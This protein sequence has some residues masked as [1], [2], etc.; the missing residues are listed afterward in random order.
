MTSWLD[1]VMGQHIPIVH[2]LIHCGLILERF[3]GKKRKK[4]F[5]RKYDVSTSWR[6]DVIDFFSSLNIRIHDIHLFRLIWRDLV[7]KKCIKPDFYANM[8]SA[9]HDVITS[10]TF[11]HHLICAYTKSIF[12]ESLK[13]IGLKTNPPESILV[14]IFRT[15]TRK[16]VTFLSNNSGTAWPILDL[17]FALERQFVGLSVRYQPFFDPGSG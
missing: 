9:R 10:S 11:F 14:V 16:T 5:L 6:Y 2:I 7:G 8:T 15:F 4:R 13:A 3:S 17:I 12:S 1:C